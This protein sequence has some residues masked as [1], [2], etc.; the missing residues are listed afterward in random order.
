VLAG[1]DPTF[2]RL[3]Q[4]NRDM[5]FR[6]TARDGSGGVRYDAMKVTV[7]GSEFR[8]QQPAQGSNQECGLPT[9][10][11]WSV[12]GGSVAPNVRA[13]YS[14]DNGANFTTL[15][16]STPNDGAQSVTLPKTLTNSTSRL[17][18]EGNGNIFFSVSRPFSVRDTLAPEVTAPGR[19]TAECSQ[20]NPPGTPK[21][22]VSLGTATATDVCAGPLAVSNNAPDVFLLGD[23]TVTWSSTD[24]S[25]NTGTDTQTVTIEDTTKPTISVTLSQTE[26]WPA[27]HQMVP[28]TATVTVEDVCDPNPAIRLVSITSNEPDDGLGDGNFSPDIAGAAYG[29]ADFAFQ[30]RAERSGLGTG[31]TYTVTYEVEDASGNKSQA[32]AR[33]YVPHDRR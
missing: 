4:V 5:N 30:L 31:R 22:E 2:E 23:N 29:T 24:P 32:Q 20:K 1:N 28:I 26:L 16:G 27:N 21:S 8:V 19:V 15:L 6:V 13:L 12:G 10:I 18:L 14:T 9:D 17:M 25:G 3:P 7:S 33:V 11:Q